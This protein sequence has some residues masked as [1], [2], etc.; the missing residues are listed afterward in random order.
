MKTA[1]GYSGCVTA[2]HRLAAKSGVDVLAAGGNAIEAMIAAAAT[3]AVVYP[4][5]N[6]I[7]GD[8]FWI[9]RKPG[10]APIAIEA[11]G[12]AAK[13]ATRDWY[14]E[15]GHEGAVAL[16]VTD[17]VGDQVGGRVHA[18]HERDGRQ[19]GLLVAELGEH[20]RAAL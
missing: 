14:R 17:H 15:R 16:G 10:E 13:L 7:G 20:D 2:P 9:I 1:M 18:R 4:H 19:L 11:C 3:I 8:G 5:M 6:S 12:Q